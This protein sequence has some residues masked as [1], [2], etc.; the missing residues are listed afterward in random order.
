MTLR[1]A[2]REN[3]VKGQHFMLETEASKQFSFRLPGEL[4]GRV[5]QC[6]DGMRAKGL[7]VSRA[8]V[9]RLLLNHALAATDCKLERLL[10]T[11]KR[12]ASVRRRK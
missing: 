8:D 9:V 7:D 1:V 5:E 6:V 2:A 11:P 10:Q 3:N 4:V 12:K